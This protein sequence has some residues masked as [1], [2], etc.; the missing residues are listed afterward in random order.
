[1]NDRKIIIAIDGHSSCG[2]STLSK[3]L[4]HKL[5]YS[6]V[7]SGSM[8]RAVTLYALRNNLIK[9]GKVDVPGLIS[10][11]STIFISFKYNPSEHKSDTYLNGENVE[12]EIRGLEVSNSVSPVAVIKEV[13]EAMVKI[14]K[15]L[16]KEK[17]IVMDG[18]DIGTVVYPDAELKIFMTASPEI[19]ARRRFEELVGKGADVSYEEILKNVEGRDFIDQNRE[20]SPLKKA[21]DS[22]VLDNSNLTRNEQLDWV[23]ALVNEIIHDHRN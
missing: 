12:A 15:E 5:Q 11:L 16:G 2:K 4:A 10:Q 17:G 18:R 9:D 19:R 7:D 22:I 21:D 23:F 3:Q 8:Y 20:V 13:R 6:Y 1:M 14:Q